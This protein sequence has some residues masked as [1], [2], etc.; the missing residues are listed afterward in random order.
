MAPERFDVESAGLE[1][2]K[3]NPLTV[4]VMKEVGIDISRN[5]TQ[6]VF[7][8]VKESKQYDYVIT[9]CSE[10]QGERCPFFPGE[11]TRLQWEFE[12]PS[13]FSGIWQEKLAKTRVVRDAIKQKIT[14]WLAE[15]HE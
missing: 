12:D 4:E 3:L 6:C 13:Q 11:N 1:P 9:V 7:D 2:G 15:S 5:A 14:Q 10:S 8:L